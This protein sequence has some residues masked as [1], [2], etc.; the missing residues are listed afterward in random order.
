MLGAGDADAT[1]RGIVWKEIEMNKI[2]EI[3]GQMKEGQFALIRK[4]VD[5]S[6]VIVYYAKDV[7]GVDLV[8]DYLGWADHEEWSEETGYSMETLVGRIWRLENEEVIFYNAIDMYVAIA[9]VNNCVI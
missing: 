4:Y 3:N 7:A 9:I 2:D 8:L 1:T 5:D 6:E